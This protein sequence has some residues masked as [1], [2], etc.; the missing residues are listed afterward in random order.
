MEICELTMAAER[1]GTKPFFVWHRR[2]TSPQ[3]SLYRRHVVYVIIVIE[4]LVTYWTLYEA[5]Q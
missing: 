1:C 3:S 4:L 2:A 5:T